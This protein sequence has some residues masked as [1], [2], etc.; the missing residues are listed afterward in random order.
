MC[1]WVP[2]ECTGVYRGARVAGVCRAGLEYPGWPRAW[3]WS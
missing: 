1:R 2:P 3:Y